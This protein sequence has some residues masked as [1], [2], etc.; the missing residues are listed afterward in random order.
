MSPLNRRQVLQRMG[1]AGAT[2]L[3]D[4]PALARSIQVEQPP[5][6]RTVALGQVSYRDLGRAMGEA[7]REDIAAVMGA[8]DK[9]LQAC[10][11]A[12]RG[13]MW[14]RIDGFREA[15]AG[16]WPHLLEEIEGMAEGANVAADLMFAWNC[17]SEIHAITQAAGCSTVGLAGPDGFVLA[18][19]EDGNAA[20]FGRMT[21]IKATPPSGNSFAYLVYPGN[22]IG[23]APGINAAGVC[24]STNFIS[25]TEVGRGLPRYFTGRAVAEATSLDEAEQLVT[26]AGRAFP[27]HHNIGSVTD[28]RLLSIETWPPDRHDTLAVDGV[29]LHT[30]HLTHDAMQGLPENLTYFDRSTGPR[31][32]ALTRLTDEKTPASKQDLLDLLADRSGSPC[33]VCRHPDDEVPG[34]TVATA[35]FTGGTAEMT[36]IE[37]APCWGRSMNVG[38]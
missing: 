8:Q 38:V 16:N 28:R 14:A 34:V 26:V 13:P 19:N 37:S 31:M 30:N 11:A 7:L 24:Q 21:V 23:N 3:V 27:W 5:P 4:L 9:A 15:V 33:K 2:A 35:V 18:H 29:H 36:L 22:L 1:A 25:C 6:F 17:R 10:E 12:L 20:Y 32:E